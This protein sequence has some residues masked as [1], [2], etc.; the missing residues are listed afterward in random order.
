MWL[1]YNWARHRIT[2]RIMNFEASYGTRFCEHDHAAPCRTHGPRCAVD[3]PES[4]NP[5]THLPHIR[6]DTIY[7]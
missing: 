2:H 4:V 3:V 1:E 5:S 7:Y 6:N